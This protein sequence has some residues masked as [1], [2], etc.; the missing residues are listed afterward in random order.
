MTAALPKAEIPR[1]RGVCPALRPV[2]AAKAPQEGV[3]RRSRG[4]GEK[5]CIK[6]CFTPSATARGGAGSLKEGALKRR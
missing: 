2:G 6:R 4:G 1:A 5:H 3:A